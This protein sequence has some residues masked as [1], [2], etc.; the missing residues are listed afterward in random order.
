MNEMKIYYVVPP[1]TCKSKEN[2]SCPDT[3]RCIA[4]SL[5]AYICLSHSQ[6]S[7]SERIVFGSLR[8]RTNDPSNM[9]S[10]EVSGTENS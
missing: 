10:P 1:D 7:N 2:N 8:R 5:G 4:E 9:S 6:E 3:V